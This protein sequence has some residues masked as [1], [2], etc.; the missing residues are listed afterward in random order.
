MYFGTSKDI[1]SHRK[2]SAVKIYCGN[3][4][5]VGC[6]RKPRLQ[7]SWFMKLGLGAISHGHWV[8]TVIVYIVSDFSVPSVVVRGGSKPILKLVLW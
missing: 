2:P 6:V 7:A 8:I 4:P 1:S 5:T 3:K